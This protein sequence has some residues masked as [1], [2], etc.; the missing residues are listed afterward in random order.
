MEWC[1]MVIGF[2]LGSDEKVWEA[3]SGDGHTPS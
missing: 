3:N 2:F 1:S